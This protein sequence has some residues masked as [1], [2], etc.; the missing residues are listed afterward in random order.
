ML[1]QRLLGSAE[2]LQ[3]IIDIIPSPVFVKDTGHRWVLMNGAM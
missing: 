2:A 3:K 1:H